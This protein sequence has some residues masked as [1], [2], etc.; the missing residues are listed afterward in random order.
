MLTQTDKTIR[1]KVSHPSAAIPTHVNEHVRRWVAECIELC[2]PD[3]VVWCDGSKSERAALLDQGV[4]E[5]VFVKLNQQRLPGCYYHRSNPNDV[6]RTE[7]LTFICTPSQD[8][9]GPTNNWMESRS[10]HATEISPF[11]PLTNFSN[12]VFNG[13]SNG[14]P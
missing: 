14:V 2:Q 10:A 3:K 1:R 13:S 6:A 12:A 4:K 8:T 9:A 5:G 11:K 7:H